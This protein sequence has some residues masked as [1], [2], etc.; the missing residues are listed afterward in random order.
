MAQIISRKKRNGIW[1]NNLSGLQSRDF[2]KNPMPKWFLSHPIPAIQFSPG[3]HIPNLVIRIIM[4]RFLR[5]ANQFLIDCQEIRSV[6]IVILKIILSRILHG[7]QI[8]NGVGRCTSILLSLPQRQIRPL[9][10]LGVWRRVI[11]LSLVP[12]I[13]GAKFVTI[14]GIFLKTVG[15]GCFAG[16]SS[17]NPRPFPKILLHQP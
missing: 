12:R 8:L 16:F 1:S 11:W 3:F 5:L 7:I 6:I 14:M 2:L 9:F 13:S 15:M 4:L 17:P 10:V